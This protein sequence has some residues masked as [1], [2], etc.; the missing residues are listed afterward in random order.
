MNSANGFVTSPEM[1][2]ANGVDLYLKYKDL[3]TKT[4]Q[5]DFLK[6]N[7]KLSDQLDCVKALESVINMIEDG[8]TLVIGSCFSGNTRENSG[9][10]TASL[11]K[12]SS[13]RINIYLN[14]DATHVNKEGEE[15]LDIPL[16]GD[17]F[18][19]G[20]KEGNSEE[21]KSTNKDLKLNS[22]R[23]KVYEDTK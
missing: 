16:S 15:F 2:T 1:I 12:L 5:E 17:N 23:S 10:L 9:D 18:L 19:K 3:S 22:K 20:W 6:N 4:E 13:G 7:P 21:V 8:G 14:Q 11:V